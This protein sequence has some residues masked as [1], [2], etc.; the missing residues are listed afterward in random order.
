MQNKARPEGSISEAYVSYESLTFCALY[1]R[2]VE[3]SFKWPERNINRGLRE[4]K[5]SVFM[6]IARPFM[7]SSMVEFTNV[8][9]EIAHWSILNNCEE[10]TPFL[11]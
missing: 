7:G 4:A 3:T 10:V 8:D 5:L 6:Q 11:K 1:L 2:N 9:I